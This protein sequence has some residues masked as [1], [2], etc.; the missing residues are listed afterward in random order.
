MRSYATVGVKVCVCGK[1]TRIDWTVG[2]IYEI[3][4]LLSQLSSE[5]KS[6]LACP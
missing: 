5:N 4:K 1:S 3:R 6:A 2:L